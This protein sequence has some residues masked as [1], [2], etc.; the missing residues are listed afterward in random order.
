M[1]EAIVIKT[2]PRYHYQPIICCEFFGTRPSRIETE[3]HRCS[4]KSHKDCI[5]HDD[6]CGRHDGDTKGLFVHIYVGLNIFAAKRDCCMSR[7]KCRHMYS[8]R[9]QNSICRTLGEMKGVLRM[10]KALS[11]A[12]FYK[13]G[14]RRVCA[15]FNR[16][17]VKVNE[18]LN[19]KQKL[20]NIL[21]K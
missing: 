1:L 4:R 13:G 6:C 12:T 14:A 5:G 20:I 17:S 9:R 11:K 8:C 18:A 15:I 16:G 10:L 2:Y 3:A 7:T 21:S 19:R